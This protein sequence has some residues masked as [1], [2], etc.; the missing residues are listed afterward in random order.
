LFELAA[1]RNV[2]T[3]IA[4]RLFF[5]RLAQIHCTI[6]HFVAIIETGHGI[7]GKMKHRRWMVLSAI[8]VCALS[9]AMMA[10]AQ[11]LTTAEKKKRFHDLLG[12]WQIK[13]YP[14]K[15]ARTY[16]ISGRGDVYFVEEDLYGKVSSTDDGVLLEFESDGPKTERITLGAD[17]RAF[18]E[19]FNPRTQ[20]PN[21]PDQIGIGV[22]RN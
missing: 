13:Y 1:A 7:G 19:H 18:I 6:P 15:A 2:S 8:V 10:H 4:G 17:G 22:R 20:F 3:H 5:V 9:V 16:V 12:T 14:N 21:N 11:S